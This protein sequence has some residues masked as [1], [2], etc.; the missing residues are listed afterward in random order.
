MKL[1]NGSI[2]MW[3]NHEV[4]NWALRIV[5]NSIVAATGSPYVHTALVLFDKVY[6][7]SAWFIGKKL[8]HGLRIRDYTD[9]IG[10]EAYEPTFELSEKDYKTMQ[11]Y[12]IWLDAYADKY[13]FLK[14]VALAIVLPFRKL[15]RALNWV[16]LD[17][18]PMGDVCSV[19]PAETY[20]VVGIDLFPN[21]LAGYTTPGMWMTLV[22]DKFIRVK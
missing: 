5:M 21:D 19:L 12:C 2:L 15:F 22:P 4:D 6:E 20:E 7:Y 14:L 16:P 13:N 1:K 18:K 8:Y 10:E 11:N 17:G 9:D 3:Q